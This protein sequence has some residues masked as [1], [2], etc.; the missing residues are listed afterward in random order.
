[1][2]RAGAGVA[3]FTFS[4]LIPGGNPTII[5]HDPGI[6]DGELAAVSARLM[7]PA[8]LQ[9]EQVGALYSG[10]ADARPSAGAE[11][12]LPR[13]LMMGGEFC[14]NAVRSSAF[15]LARQGRLALRAFPGAVGAVGEG[16][17]LASGME[18]PVR[19]LAARDAGSLA[20]AIEDCSVF[21]LVGAPASGEGPPADAPL[22]YCAVEVSCPLPKEACAP[23]QKGACLVSLPGISHVLVDMER[24]PLP[25]LSG[26]AWKKESAAWRT[27][28]G[29]ANL[30]A[31]GV[32]WY[33]RDGGGYRIWPAVAVRATASEHLETACG[34]ASLALALLHASASADTAGPWP[35]AV[36]IGQP[37]GETLTVTLAGAHETGSGTAPASVPPGCSAWVAGPVLLAAEGRAYV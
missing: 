34:S 8:H 7:S 18:K 5:L 9:A 36:G 10:G 4:K 28:S 23:L 17:V 21:P 25:D 27:L 2:T 12:S 3:A 30:P 22:L 6:E 11:D 16:W 33:G 14:V 13:L 32:V 24:H 29:I 1:M 26:E 19:V 31:S 20:G 15:C 35:V 37:S